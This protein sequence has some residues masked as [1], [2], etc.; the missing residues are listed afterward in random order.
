MEEHINQIGLKREDVIDK[1]KHFRDQIRVPENKN[2]VPR[3]RK[4]YV[5][6]IKRKTDLIIL[7]LVKY[8][9]GPYRSI[10]CIQTSYYAV[11]MAN[12]KND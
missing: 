9:S 10:R 7:Y 4:N 1:T 5:Y 12:S 11:R 3:I 8:F 2:W 6:V